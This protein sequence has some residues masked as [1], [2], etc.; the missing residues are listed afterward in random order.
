[1]SDRSTEERLADLEARIA[2]LE[3]RSEHVPRPSAAT[4]GDGALWVLEGIRQQGSPGGSVVY[5]GHLDGE[6]GPVEWQYGLGAEDLTGLDWAELATTLDALGNP[7]RL[8][9]LRAVWSGVSTVAELKEQEGFGTTGQIYHHVNLLAAAGWLTTRRRGHY[10][11][12][13]DR[14]VPLLVILA[15]AKGSL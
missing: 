6:E 15:A 8:S 9:I 4:P 13:I 11:V 5:A 1:M 10:V 3:Q 2:E 7:V 14:R 12:P